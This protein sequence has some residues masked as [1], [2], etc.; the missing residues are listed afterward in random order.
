MIPSTATRNLLA[1]VADLTI[2][3]A[4]LHK[5]LFDI[6]QASAGMLGA[7]GSAQN[8]WNRATVLLE[9]LAEMADK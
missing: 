3:H 6:V 7:S 4:A 1:Q 2:E 5:A 9:R 8:A